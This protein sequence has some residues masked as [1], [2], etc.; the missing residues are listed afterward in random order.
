MSQFMKIA[1]FARD[2]IHWLYTIDINTWAMGVDNEMN[3][4]TGLLHQM[5]NSVDVSY[6]MYTELIMTLL[7][8][9]HHILF[10]Y[11]WLLPTSTM[12]CVYSF[13]YVEYLLVL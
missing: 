4:T 10:F 6:Q 5:N 11:W 7:Q 9:L 13:M 8:C 1:H 2:D 12:I 3:F